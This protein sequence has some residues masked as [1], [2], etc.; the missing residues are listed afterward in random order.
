M[1]VWWGFETGLDLSTDLICWLN[2]CCFSICFKHS[3]FVISLC[4]CVHVTSTI[5]CLLEVPYLVV[6]S[7][8]T[9]VCSDLEWLTF[10]NWY[11]SMRTV[12]LDLGE[13]D[14]IWIN[15]LFLPV[16]IAIMFR[17]FLDCNDGFGWK[18]FKL[19]FIW[20]WK[21]LEFD[22]KLIFLWINNLFIYLFTH[23]ILFLI[24][25]IEWIYLVVI[26]P[27]K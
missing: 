3:W 14:F 15:K 2:G 6:L 20:G 18:Y 25:A 16:L 24:N 8:E 7:F 19:R 23:F 27:I 12:Y 22:L 10:E 11:D 5:C 4:M 9:G 21:S 13:W 1:R 17:V 26:T